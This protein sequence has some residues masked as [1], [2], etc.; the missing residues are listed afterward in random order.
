MNGK[1]VQSQFQIYTL[2]KEIYPSA[3]IEEK[4]E[5][6]YQDLRNKY[7]NSFA[8]Q[9]PTLIVRVPY[10]ITLF[11]DNI[12]KMFPDKIVS[13]LSNDVIF[14]ISKNTENELKVKFY[15][16]LY[17]FKT[18]IGSFDVGTV[19]KKDDEPVELKDFIINGYLSG[20]IQSKSKK[21]VG[22]NILMSLNTTDLENNNDLFISSFLG[23]LISSLYLNDSLPKT[24]NNLYETALL[25]LSK[26]LKENMT[27]YASY[28][29]FKI[30]LKQNSLGFSIGNSFFQNEI[31]NYQ[32]FKQ[33]IFDSFSPRPIMSY[34]SAHYW[35]KRKVE[36][37]LG[38][39]LILKR[40]K[41]NITEEELIKNTSDLS[42][43]LKIFENNAE[44]VLQ[45]LEIYLKKEMY[46]KDEIQKELNMDLLKLLQGIDFPEGA[47]M[48]K[49]FFLYKRL[50]FLFKEYQ[51]VIT[52]YAQSRVNDKIDWI[53]KI[54]KSGES[55]EENYSC[56]S[57][58][59]K[60][61]I[62]ILK[63]THKKI[64][65]KVIS[66]GWSGQIAVVGIKEEIAL[67]DKEI[68]EYYEKYN[69]NN[70]DG[71]VSAWISDDINKYCFTSDFCNCMCLLDPKYEDFMLDYVTMKNNVPEPDENKKNKLMKEN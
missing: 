40:Y 53:E 17:E 68:C 3:E 23:S 1:E 69:E 70:G 60:K 61:L 52:L 35:N 54:S 33:F 13:N 14:L 31:E 20:L 8:S 49:D 67:V 28:L 36:C 6:I 5:P 44:T 30:F 56:Y 43:F 51:T 59:M 19:M 24:K 15:D 2:L 25:S 11:G 18:S 22:A 41:E 55:M 71:L 27:Y 42:T 34:S 29:Y 58:E 48:T 64:G 37:R 66:N 21:F 46:T 63:N 39:A 32:K 62:N 57:D 9:E 26:L 16:Q 65:I 7:R 12:T 38:M 4:Y 50:L 47:L 45:M 10:T